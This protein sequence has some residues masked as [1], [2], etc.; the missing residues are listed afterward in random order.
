MSKS[1]T[2]FQRAADVIL[3]RFSTSDFISVASVASFANFT[4][5]VPEGGGLI[6]A[7]S[8]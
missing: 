4:G 3:L 6:G 1:N 8:D 7:R 5:Q 2:R